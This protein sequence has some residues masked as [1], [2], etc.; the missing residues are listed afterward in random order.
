MDVQDLHTSVADGLS[1]AE[2]L[3]PSSSA[4]FL[5]AKFYKY[6][7]IIHTFRTIART[8]YLKMEL[9]PS[10]PFF[11]D[12]YLLQPTNKSLLMHL[13]SP[14]SKNSFTLQSM[15][16]SLFWKRV[17][18]KRPLCRS[19]GMPHPCLVY[20]VCLAHLPSVPKCSAKE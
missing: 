2:V 12:I 20:A 8:P 9:M 1:T 11:N 13:T 7:P 14:M 6:G 19:R 10:T 18:I 3:V 15:C 5:L 4:I 16:D 17:R